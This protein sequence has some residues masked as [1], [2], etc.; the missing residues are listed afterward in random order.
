MLATN[1]HGE[2]VSFDCHKVIVTVP[3]SILQ[4]GT[5]K[6]SPPLPKA[7]QVAISRIK[8]GQYKKVIVYFHDVFWNDSEG[9]LGQEPFLH[10]SFQK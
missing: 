5:I 6:F 9:G 10:F 8:M 7:K 4:A 2:V 3:V 1:Q